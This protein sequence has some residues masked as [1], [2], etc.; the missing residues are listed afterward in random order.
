[1][2]KF[3]SLLLTSLSLLASSAAF[4]ASPASTLTRAEVT[5]EYVR[6]RAAG[7]VPITGYETVYSVKAPAASGLTRAEVQAEYARAR[8]A[9]ELNDVSGFA[10]AIRTVQGATTLTRADVLNEYVRARSTGEL[11]ENSNDF[12]SPQYRRVMR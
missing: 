6:A 7:E 10:S 8:Q 11:A 3:N 9:G 4:A 12:G 5:A 1:M 2:N